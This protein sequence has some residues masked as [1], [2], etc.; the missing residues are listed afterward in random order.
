MQGQILY[1]TMTIRNIQSG[2]VA[3]TWDITES[4]STTG[5]FTVGDDLKTTNRSSL[6]NIGMVVPT[7]NDHPISGQEQLM[8]TYSGT[9]LSFG[10][11]NY[12][13][14]MPFQY[15]PGTE[16]LQ[17]G[18]YMSGY[19]I[20]YNDGY[21]HTEYA[22]YDLHNGIVPVSY[23]ELANDS[24]QVIV[25]VVTR[26]SGGQLDITHLFTFMKN[27]K[28]IKMDLDIANNYGGTMSQVVYK[29][30]ADWDIDSTYDNDN[31]GYD[32][33]HNMI[34]AWDVH[35]AAIAAGLPPDYRD[36]DGWD[37]YYQR[38]TDQDNPT[39]PIYGFDGMEL[40]HY[41]LGDIVSGN[42]TSLSFAY[43][44][45]DS[46]AELQQVV[47]RAISLQ[48]DWLDENPKSGATATSSYSL[49][50]ITFNATNLPVGD[51]S[52]YIVVTSNDPDESVEFVPVTLHV[53]PGQPQLNVG[54]DTINF[55]SLYVGG[56]ADSV[57]RIT[58]IGYGTLTVTN[59]AISGNT[60]DFSRVDTGDFYLDKNQYGDII[61]RFAPSTIGVSTGLLSFS[62]NDTSSSDTTVVLIGTGVTAPDIAV[63]LNPLPWATVIQGSTTYG[64]FTISNTGGSDLSY[65]IR[66]AVSMVTIAGFSLGADYYNLESLPSV[67]HDPFS[68]QANA[69]Y[70]K[71]EL[72][73]KFKSTANSLAINAINSEVGVQQLKYYPTIGVTRLKLNSGKNVAEA[74]ATYAKYR[75]Q[76]EYAEPNYI[77]H[78]FRMPNDPDFAQLWGL[79][80]T[81]QTGGT[82]D[83][84]ID[85][86]EAWNLSIGNSNVIIG[87]ID[88]GVDY[89]HPD[90]KNNIWHNPDEIPFNSIDD[91]GNGYVDDTIGWDFV[92][93]DNNPMDDNDHGSHCS[94]TIAGEGNNGIGVVGVNWQAKIMPLKFLDDSGS[95]STAD[96]VEAVLYAAKMG[97]K[98][99]SN[100]WGGGGY[101]SSL[102][103]AISAAN[104][105]GQLFVAAAGNDYG[106]NNDTNPTYPASYDLPNVIAVAA[107][108]DDDLLASFS[109]YGPTSVDVGAPGVNI[110]S[111]IPGGYDSFNGTSMATPHVSGACALIWSMNL[112]ATPAQVKQVLVNS[113]DT[114][115]ALIGKCATNGRIN[116]YKALQ[117]AGLSWLD[118]NPKSGT[119]ATA[120][121]S[122]ITVVYDAS[123]L[124][125]GDTSGYIIITS[126]D[127]D[128][129][130]VN[131]LASLHVLPGIPKLSV[132]PSSINYGSVY[133]GVSVNNPIRI[134]NS[135][136]GILT[137]SNIAITSGSSDYVRIW[138][139]DIRLPRNQYADI[140]ARFIP[141]AAGTRTGTLTIYS[142]VST[143][144]ISLTGI[145]IIPPDIDIQPTAF[146][147]T[148]LQG[149]ILTDIMTVRNT[150]SSGTTLSWQIAESLSDIGI[151]GNTGNEDSRFRT[152]AQLP[153]IFGVNPDRYPGRL[154]K[155]SLNI[156]DG[157]LIFSGSGWTINPA[158]NGARYRAA[159]AAVNGKIY[160][161]GGWNSSD[162]ASNSVEMFDPNLGTWVSKTNK[163]TALANICC[164]VIGNKIY[165]AGGYDN[166]YNY[167]SELEIYDTQYDTW[168]TGASLPQPFC[169]A[170]AAVVNGKL[171]VVGGSSSSGKLNTCYEYNP[172]ANSW[173]QKSSMNY[174]RNYL[175]AAAINNKIYA[176]GGWTSSA[177]AAYCEEYDPVGNTWTVKSSMNLARGDL[178]VCS[179]GNYIY[180]IGG[181]SP[182]S[183]WTTVVERYS[184]LTNSWTMSSTEIPYLNYA[185]E[186]LSMAVNSDGTMYALAGF[187]GT[188]R[189]VNESYNC[190]V[191]DWLDET[192]TAGVNPSGTYSQITVTFDATSLPTGE[193]TGYF[194]VSSNDPDE[195]P[196]SI[197]VTLLIYNTGIPS[198]SLSPANINYGTVTIGFG[199]DI[200]IQ[201]T[202]VGYGILTVNNII[203][204]SAEYY[205]IGSVNLQ[206]ARN[207]S[208]EVPI[209][210]HPNS[211]GTRT[212]TLS[213][214]SNDPVFPITTINL[215]GVGVLP[216]TKVPS[217]VWRKY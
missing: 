103:A 37:D 77:V 183:Y 9:Y 4:S 79:N 94:G 161:I 123:E 34:Y 33:T 23:T 82:P 83:A 149:T 130:P 196:V 86:P 81:G 22:A 166:S 141:S 55:G 198:I 63:F 110:Y 38:T 179:D 133:T 6:S 74:I 69:E 78:N 169:G 26:T 217:E 132:S 140:T 71:D 200:P 12:G 120:T 163:P 185:R 53:L 105:A 189:D 15:P 186:G 2:S 151:L 50:T 193:T 84:D 49:V 31:W 111:T 195:T 203:A 21:D 11:S 93:N 153:Y 104:V 91:D 192:L 24:S 118:E 99:T 3:L 45:A 148:M 60:T 165:V 107:T 201:I 115:A 142:N 72:L 125:I 124:P 32:S 209:R 213:I 76:V 36:I 30:F 202:N 44:A 212:A 139:G 56:S 101:S 52:G 135:G 156:D 121:Y 66:D 181:G 109:N 43:A 136:Y 17:V 127:P 62:S 28:Y 18:S 178:G 41:D 214:Y 216:P 29:S 90:L 25:K 194:I 138:S 155:N 134:T 14:I 157:E 117:L 146:S 215:S 168:T 126:N 51:T 114:V 206:L 8:A 173:S 42:T 92:N 162:V 137:V 190:D 175:G 204:N 13:E 171:Y 100:S 160:I 89:T 88:T 187:S 68:I 98:L 113:V 57:L 211:A 167:H 65:T 210:F 46:F 122:I 170:G 39:G 154:T 174:A 143:A 150:A 87:V 40:L 54:L 73:V 48:F 1:D 128:E 131:V 97:V 85:A 80:N 112:S 197:P 188:A 75:D 205:P 158:M 96:A 199:L 95:G 152:V 207:Q 108:D 129:N 164:G 27:D 61:V 191:L 184:P 16:H 144:S 119:I 64:Q 116:I 102:Y 70:A 19:T 59:I 5:I 20:C 176:I 7:L 67:K 159:A 147:K 182:W 177:N 35:Y 10:I 180:A 58:N 172:V 47:D 208:V 106:N 145:G